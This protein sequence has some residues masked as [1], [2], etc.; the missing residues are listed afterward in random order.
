MKDTEVS[1]EKTIHLLHEL[2]EYEERCRIFEKKLINT[3]YEL[4]NVVGRSEQEG[5]ELRSQIAIMQNELTN[6]DEKLKVNIIMNNIFFFLQ[7]I[8]RK[9]Y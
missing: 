9:I 8:I 1:Q 6:K 4:K 7:K 5:E 3:Q 2:Q